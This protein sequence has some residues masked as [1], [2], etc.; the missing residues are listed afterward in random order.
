MQTF[1][2]KTADLEITLKKGDTWY[3]N[4]LVKDQDDNSINLSGYTSAKL[5]LRESEFSTPA[6]T[7][8]SLGETIDISNLAAGQ[9]IIN[10]IM[11]IDAGVYYADFELSNNDR[12]ETIFTA[13]INIEHDYTT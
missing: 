9:I 2:T 13:K 5:Q 7:L 8:N 4:F 11:N 10:S 3:F 1:T 6:L 12:I